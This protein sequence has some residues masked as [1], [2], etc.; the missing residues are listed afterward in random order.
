[1]TIAIRQPVQL[2]K[3]DRKLGIAFGHGIVCKQMEDG[4]LVDYYDLQGD[5]IP[6]DVMLKAAKDFAV[7]A[8]VG[9]V[10]HEGEQA[11][12]C[13]FVFPMTADIAKGLGFTGDRYGLLIGYMP[14]DSAMLDKVEAGEFP[15]LSMGGN[16]VRNPVAS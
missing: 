15:G 16:A 11:G 6:E 14:R 4:Q 9:K 10:Q 13:V 12:D 5:H 2:L 7:G 3:V 1:V 8:R